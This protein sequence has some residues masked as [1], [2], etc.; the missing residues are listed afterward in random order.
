[1]K[2]FLKVWA[3]LCVQISVLFNKES[4]HYISM[5]FPRS[6][7]YTVYN[8]LPVLEIS[9]SQAVLICYPILWLQL[10]LYLFKQRRSKLRPHGE[11][12]K[13]RKWRFKFFH[14]CLDIWGDNSFIHSFYLPGSFLRKSLSAFNYVPLRP[15]PSKW[16]IK[17]IFA[18]LHY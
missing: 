12:G 5:Q 3:F 13:K 7:T 1:M 9:L 10:Y 16:I 8:F 4:I 11:K 17:W 18:N 14:A 15:S 6:F 2:T